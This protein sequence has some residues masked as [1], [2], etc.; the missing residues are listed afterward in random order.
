MEIFL[1]A[2]AGLFF[3]GILLSPVALRTGAPLLL[4]FLVIGMLAGENGPGGIQFDDFGLAYDLGS[5]AL[6]II[7]FTGGLE[8]HVGD[9]KKAWVPAMAL[10]SV[11]V[12]LTAGIVGG[13]VTLLLGLP[14]EQALL[15]GA[16]VGSTD[17]AATFMLLQQRAINLVGRGKETILIESGLNDPFAIFLTIVFVSIVDDGTASFGWPTMLIFVSQ[18]GLG[19][20]LGL[21]G[22]IVL[23][24]LV[25]RTPLLPG[26]Y[27]VLV[28]S[29]GLLLFGVT[30][31][32]GG[33]GFLA[34]YLCG[35][36]VNSR[37]TRADER[38]VNFHS[39]MAWLS[40]IGL[41]LMLGLLVTPCNLPTAIPSALV[42]AAVLMFVARPLATIVCLTPLRFPLRQQLF[43][44]WVGLRG[45]VPIFLAIIPVIS[46]GP[47]SV[48]FFNEVFVVV[49]SSLVLQG[50][51][52]SLAARV[53]KVE[54]PRTPLPVNDAQSAPAMTKGPADVA[55]SIPLSR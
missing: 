33:S 40:Q 34:V 17:A 48:R 44:G 51:S 42:I 24:W 16:V 31:W 3:F 21:A 8:T 39:A 53:L 27:S 15:F 10:A 18:I 20:A 7:L 54:A 41:F 19:V 11:G 38:I 46:S 55:E 30:A 4:F 28:L 43:I 12:C 23:V 2:G 22:G 47:V 45:A 6:A 29:G 32:L 5:V 9:I 26:M 36:V 37:C 25:N 13:A 49:I 50:W 35:I 14:L 1:I 52:I